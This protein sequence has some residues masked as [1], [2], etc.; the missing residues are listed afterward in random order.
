MASNTSAGPDTRSKLWFSPGLLAVVLLSVV[1]CAC[2]SKVGRGGGGASTSSTGKGS[3]GLSATGEEGGTPGAVPGQGSSPGGDNESKGASNQPGG[4]TRTG[5]GAGGATTRAGA[6]EDGGA[7]NQPGGT[8]RAGA[9]AGGATTRAGAGQDGGAVDQP[10]GATRAGTGAG[11]VTTHAGAGEQG[12]AVGQPGGTTRIGAGAG[13]T[14]TR[15][16][17]GEDGG[18]NADGTS[19]GGGATGHAGGTTRA[20]TR[21]GGATTRAGAGGDEESEQLA[22]GTIGAPGSRAKVEEEVTAQT[23]D[24]LLPLVV[25]VDEEGQFDFDQA[26]LRPEV[27]VRLDELAAKLDGAQFDRLD[28]V[29]YADPIGTEEYNQQ[30]SERR[31]WAVARYLLDKSVP[32][33]KMKVEGRGQRNSL[34]PEGSCSGLS[35]PEMIACVQKDRRVEIEASIRK[36]NVKVQ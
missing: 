31:A 7:I 29:G 34:I 3:S 20:G 17:M 33:K 13:G 35:K 4:T 16:G 2:A 24:G 22:A 8:T 36:T 10:G 12:G 28:I 23:L 30:L 5:A 15:A 9:G 25:G 14:S 18:L 26:V 21:A 27:K 1:L 32:L 19:S 6:G 11:G